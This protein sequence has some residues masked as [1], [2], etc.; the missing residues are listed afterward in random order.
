MTGDGQENVFVVNIFSD[1]LSMK[2]IL[3]LQ[4]FATWPQ[5]P[6]WHSSFH[7][8]KKYVLE[9]EVGNVH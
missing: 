7:G 3:E 8:I 2:F 6:K 1:E 4:S 5:L 9:N